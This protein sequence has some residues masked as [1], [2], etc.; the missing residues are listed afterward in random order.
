MFHMR[1]QLHA[2]KAYN[3]L[4]IQH[5]NTITAHQKRLGSDYSMNIEYNAMRFSRSRWVES[6]WMLFL[7]GSCIKCVAP[8]LNCFHLSRTRLKSNDRNNCV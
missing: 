1:M 8:L 4:L 7:R 2:E 5:R 3:L 6:E